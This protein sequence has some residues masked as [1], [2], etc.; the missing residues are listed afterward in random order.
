MAVFDLWGFLYRPGM[1]LVVDLFQ[2]MG[3]DMGIDLGRGQIGVAQKLLDGPKVGAPVQEVGGEAVTQRMGRYGL[4]DASQGRPPVQDAAHAADV[5]P[6]AVLVDE[7]GVHAAHEPRGASRSFPPF[8][9][10][11][12][13]PWSICR[14]L[15]SSPVASLTR[16]PPP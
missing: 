14:S 4:L 7:D 6:G 8:P 12:A 2:A 13:K 10:T 5:E 1:R 16:N 3:G 9:R 15:R 11:T